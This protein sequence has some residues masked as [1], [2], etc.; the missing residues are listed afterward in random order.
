MKGIFSKFLFTLFCCLIYAMAISAVLDFAP[1][2]LTIALFGLGALLGVSLCYFYRF[3]D[4]GFKHPRKSKSAHNDIPPVDLKSLQPRLQIGHNSGSIDAAPGFKAC[5]FI[6]IRAIT[7][8]N[9]TMQAPTLKDCT[10]VWTAFFYAITKSLRDQHIVD[11]IYACF[12]DTASLYIRDSDSRTLTLRAIRGH[13]HQFRS[14]LNSSGID[15]RTDEGLEDLWMNLSHYVYG[16]NPP[17]DAT[18]AFVYNV[19]MLIDHT[20][21]AYEPKPRERYSLDASRVPVN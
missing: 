18:L 2:A 14:F 7:F 10:Y 16:G 9:Q 3:V 5:K 13:Y 1:G 21:N 17:K 15:P 19:R 20:K 12:D 11:D 6:W 4:N 8:C